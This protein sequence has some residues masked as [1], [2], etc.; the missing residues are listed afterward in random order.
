MIPRAMKPHRMLV[1]DYRGS[2]ATGPVYGP[3]RTVRCYVEAKSFSVRSPEGRTVAAAA[4]IRCDLDRSITPESRIT[5]F[6]RRCEI[7]S[8]THYDFPGAPSHTEVTVQ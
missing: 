5:V 7:V 8:V 2:T 6:G 4:V 1:E 3:P